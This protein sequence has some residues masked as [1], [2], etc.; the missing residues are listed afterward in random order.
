[1]M[2]IAHERETK[3]KKLLH[4]LFSGNKQVGMSLGR[5]FWEFCPNLL[6]KSGIFNLPVSSSQGFTSRMMLDLAISGG[7]N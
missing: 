1:M 3:K 5:N 2:E 4:W 7:S 6:K